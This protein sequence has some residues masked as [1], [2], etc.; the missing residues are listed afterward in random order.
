MDFAVSGKMLRFALLGALIALLCRSAGLADTVETSFAITV[1]KLDAPPSMNGDIDASWAKAVQVPVNFDFTYQR[2]G[3]ETIAYIAQDASALDVAFVVTQKTPLTAN[4]QT[5]GSGVMSDDSV[6]IV[7]FPQGTQGFQYEFIA[8]PK[9]ARDQTSSENTSYEPQWTA[10][11]RKSSTG[12]V[13][14]MRIPFDIIRSGHSSRWR[15]QM[16]RMVVATNSMLVWSHTAGQRQATDAAFAGIL[17]GI[18]S[19]DSSLRPKPRLQIYGLGE[20]TTKAN[21]GDTSRIGADIALPVSA[22]SSLLATLHPDYSNLETDQQT[23]A[24][25]AYARRYN[26]VRPF[27]TQATANYNYNFSCTNCPTTLYTPAIPTFGEGYAYEGTQGPFTFGAFNAVGTGRSDSGEALNY[28]VSDSR[29]VYGVNLQNVAVN[30]PGLHDVTAT[31]Q[32]GYQNQHTHFFVYFNSGTDRGTNVTDPALGDYFEYGGGYVS[33]LTTAGITL[34]KIGELFAPADGYV[35]QTDIAGYAPFFKR[36]YNFAATAPLRDM[37]V[38]LFYARF[39]DH[40]GDTAQTDGSAQLT[41]DFRDLL[42]LQLSTN[43]SGARTTYSNELLPYDQNGFQVGYKTDTTTPTTITYNGGL[44]HHGHLTSWSYVT[45]QP[46]APALNLSL[47]ADESL[48]APHN[49]VPEPVAQ[50]WLERASLDWQF[51]RDASIVVGAR[52]IIG[53]NLPNSFQAPDISAGAPCGTINGFSPFDCVNAGNVS[54]AFHL[55]RARDEY[56]VV[57]GN[58]NALATT[59][60]LYVKWIRYIGAEKGT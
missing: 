22:T 60:A 30:A 44:Y 39:H 1:P 34:Q 51:S 6:G 23:I 58:P 15:A 20:L 27:F 7:L 13:V 9:G 26:E 16:Y 28:N 53:R 40:H 37:I 38:D 59:P 8:N 17:D 52:R 43:A 19:S 4:E 35:A 57:Y 14:T 46:L 33:Q 2:P 31:Q 36:T 24:P 25:N 12:Y 5:N 45:T 42:S 55:L 48:Y 41:L 56:Y 11:G 50:Q 18:A 54:F 29:A 21:G 49:A 3:E 47:E 10:V 32:S